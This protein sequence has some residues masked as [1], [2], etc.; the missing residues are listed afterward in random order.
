MRYPLTELAMGGLF[1]LLYASFGLT[2]PFAVLS[3]FTVVLLTMLVAD[4]ETGLIP[5]EIHF[6]LLPLGIGYHSVMGSDPMAIGIS[7][8]VALLIGLCLHYGYFW[9]RGKHGLGLGDVKFLLVA[10]LWLGDLHAL[11]V[12]I[13]FSGLIGVEMGLIWKIVMKQ[14]RFPF[15]PA[16]GLSLW[17]LTCYPVSG[18]VFWTVLH[19]IM[20]G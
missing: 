20:I 5:D 6:V 19:R 11:V 10:G 13:F 7:A 15:G 16:L 4:L 14:E 2:I 17:V 12:F 3:A 1:L 9:L 8:G 18:N